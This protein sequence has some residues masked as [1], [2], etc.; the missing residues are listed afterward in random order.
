MLCDRIYEKN[1]D[2]AVIGFFS[3]NSSHIIT[4]SY[5]R[6]TW[7]LKIRI[8]L[9]LLQMKCLKISS[10]QLMKKIVQIGCREIGATFLYFC[11]E[12]LFICVDAL[13]CVILTQTKEQALS[14][15]KGINCEHEIE[16]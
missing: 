13:R 7:G 8:I 16:Q 14:Y 5:A 6:R 10:R 1:Y 12:D 15:L 3:V 4:N 11:S 9:L 2:D